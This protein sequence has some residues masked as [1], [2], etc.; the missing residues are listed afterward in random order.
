[1]KQDG[2]LF[3]IL[4]FGNAISNTKTNKI[5]NEEKNALFDFLLRLLT[6]NMAHAGRRRGKYI[7]GVEQIKI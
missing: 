2:H 5:T 7:S 4:K 3:P 6:V 1:M